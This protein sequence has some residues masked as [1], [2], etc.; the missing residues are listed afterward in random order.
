MDEEKILILLKGEDKTTQI[1]NFTIN[2]DE[3]KIKFYNK[4]TI[5][6]YSSEN[7]II[8]K[9]PINIDLKGKDIYYNNQVLFSVQKAIRFGEF[10]KIFYKNEETQIMEYDNISFK[11]DS[12]ENLNKN[13]I[14]YF[15]EIS[16]YIKDIDGEKDESEEN[17]QKDSFLKREYEKLNYIN[18]ESI[19]NYYINKIDLIKP[20][21]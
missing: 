8:C 11:S 9:E 14:E 1:E 18:N 16:T 15:R 4:E 21:K 12:T 5:Y 10:I 20:V 2:N 13:V 19:L 3:T 6:P 7:V 17:K